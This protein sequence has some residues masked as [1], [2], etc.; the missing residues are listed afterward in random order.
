[1]Y[2]GGRLFTIKIHSQPKKKRKKKS[3]VVILI[4]NKKQNGVYACWNVAPRQNI[5]ARCFQPSFFGPYTVT[6]LLRR[7]I[8]IFYLFEKWIS[9]RTI[10]TFRRFL[11]CQTDDWNLRTYYSDTNTMIINIY[12][13]CDRKCMGRERNE[14]ALGPS[15]N[16]INR[17]RSFPRD[18]LKTK[19][20][21][22][23]IVFLKFF[24]HKRRGAVTR[25]KRWTSS[26]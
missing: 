16:P 4:K 18:K 19:M 6:E 7:V 15:L 21:F 25:S 22:R 10:M 1:M 14:W 20:L 11:F 5:F 8:M 12:E 23:L 3:V 13:Q 2:V 26:V 24:Y 17:V 9:V